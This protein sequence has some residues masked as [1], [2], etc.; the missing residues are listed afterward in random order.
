MPRQ[1]PTDLRVQAD[2]EHAGKHPLHD[3]RYITTGPADLTDEDWHRKDTSIVA[4]MTDCEQQEAL[5]YAF[6]AAPA[7]R[8]I[9]ERIVTYHTDPE[10]RIEMEADAFRATD[11]NVLA[12]EGLME[13]AR[14]AI[15]LATPPSK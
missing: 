7:M 8:A 1:L 15:S 9:L 12:F 14:T 5:A 2:P 6:A 3:C 4:T 10:A 13:A 11:G